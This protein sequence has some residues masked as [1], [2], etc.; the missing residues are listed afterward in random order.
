MMPAVPETAGVLGFRPEYYSRR[1]KIPG[2]RATKERA[3]TG[4]RAWFK[5]THP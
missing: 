4:E 1:A 3:D 2:I 5:R